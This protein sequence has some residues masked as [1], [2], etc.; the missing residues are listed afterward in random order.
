MHPFE[1]AQPTTR[2]RPPRAGRSPAAPRARSQNPA[3]FLAGGT[4]ADRPDQAERRNAHPPD[5]RHAAAPDQ[6]RADGGRRRCASARWSRTRDLAHDPTVIKT[7]PDALP[8]HPAGRVGPAAQ[9]GDDRRQHPAADPLLLL[10]RHGHA[11][12]QARAR[13]RL[14]RHRRLQPHPRGPRAR[15]TSASRR[16]P[17]TCAS[18][19]AALDAVDPH[20]AAR[21]ARAASPFTDFHLPPGDH[22]EREN[23]LEPGEL[24]T[25][26][27]L[28]ALPFAARSHYL[29]VRD[30][31]SYAFALA[32]AAVALDIER[33]HDPA[34]P[35]RPG[36]RRHQALAGVR[37]REGA[38]GQGPHPR[39]TSAPPPTPPCTA[40]RRYGD[41]AFKIELA[42]RTLV[43]CLTRRSARW[44]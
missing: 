40:R 22:P 20:A 25:A 32:S 35:H 21:R 36:R 33:R 30:R 26:V 7:L 15:A 4:N 14:L 19:L 38:G 18:P 3:R 37:R 11:L 31:A 27:E 6:D 10:P 13:L 43:R 16:T 29:K 1:Y 44:R 2:R 5:R 39:T 34:G 8:G 17:R 9:H 24:I 41:N 12:Q 28:P 42:K 23:V